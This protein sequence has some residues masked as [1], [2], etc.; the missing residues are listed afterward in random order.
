MSNEIEKKQESSQSVEVTELEDAML[1]LAVGGVFA[2]QS[3]KGLNISCP[4]TNNT[5]AGCGASKAT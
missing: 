4:V 3:A 5:V 1:D 2:E